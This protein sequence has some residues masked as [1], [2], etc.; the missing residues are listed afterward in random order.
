MFPW[1]DQGVAIEHGVL[2]E[3]DD[4]SVVL[5]NHVMAILGIP[6]DDF[7][8]EAGAMLG[9]MD[10]SFCVKR[11]ALG[12]SRTSSPPRMSLGKVVG[13]SSFEHLLAN[14]RERCRVGNIIRELLP[15]YNLG[16]TVTQEQV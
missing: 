12:Q 4:C 10:V 6:R 14:E 15:V 13:L 2:V 3:E 1:R 16:D 8:D 7:A 11:L 9:T 5:M